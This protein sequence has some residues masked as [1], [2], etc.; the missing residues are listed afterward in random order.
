MS[1]ALSMGATLTFR[2]DMCDIFDVL[3]RFAWELGAG[4]WCYFLPLRTEVGWKAAQWSALSKF[5]AGC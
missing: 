1:L 2:A 3:G 4:V 5:D